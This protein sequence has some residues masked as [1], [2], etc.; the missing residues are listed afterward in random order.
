MLRKLDGHSDGSSEQK[1]C[2]SVTNPHIVLLGENSDPNEND[3]FCPSI[4][5]V[6]FDALGNLRI[7][8]KTRCLQL[9]HNLISLVSNPFF[10]NSNFFQMLEMAKE[11]DQTELNARKEC[12]KAKEL[13]NLNPKMFLPTRWQPQNAFCHRPGNK[14][15]CRRKAVLGKY[16]VVQLFMDLL[17]ACSC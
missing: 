11:P 9:F 16:W 15:L 12:A 5:E 14:D 8:A 6:S 3:A 17:N 7:E 13:N 10:S 1:S 4:V 2:I